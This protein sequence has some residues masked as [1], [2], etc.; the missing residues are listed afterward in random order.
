M[1]PA[2]SMSI[3]MRSTN[4]TRVEFGPVGMGNAND[5]DAYT[6]YEGS[7]STATSDVRKFGGRNKGATAKRSVGVKCCG[8]RKHGNIE[9]DWL[10]AC[11]REGGDEENG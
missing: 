3:G 11:A 4:D 2:R 9:S 10:G 7:C 5:D 6:R 1:D 8:R